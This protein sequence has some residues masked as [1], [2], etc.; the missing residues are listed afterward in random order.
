[1]II[2]NNPNAS[3]LEEISKIPGAYYKNE[4]LFAADD[5]EG[6]LTTLIGKRPD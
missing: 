6:A 4:K 5:L 2:W 1:M 3:L